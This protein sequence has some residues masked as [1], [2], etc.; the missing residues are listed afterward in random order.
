MYSSRSA[1]KPF[2]HLEDAVCNGR[3]LTKAM[4]LT[5]TE[6]IFRSSSTT[7]K[8]NRTEPT[9]CFTVKNKPKQ[10]RTEEKKSF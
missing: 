1:F 10:N 9:I 7:K 8:P 4:R 6:P 2:P 5:E 3:A